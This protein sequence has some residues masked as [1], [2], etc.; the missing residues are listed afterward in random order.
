MSGL[1][2]TPGKRLYGESRTAGS[3]PALSARTQLPEVREALVHLLASNGLHFRSARL[4]TSI[5][6]YG[7]YFRYACPE[8]VL[9]GI[10]HHFC[11]TGECVE[12]SLVPSAATLRHDHLPSRRL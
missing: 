3:N 2:R 12:L 10:G 11:E 5:R 6:S 4:R 8:T 9:Y 7:R 1:S